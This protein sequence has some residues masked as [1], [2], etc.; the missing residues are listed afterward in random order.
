[1]IPNASI[2]STIN[3]DSESMESI[4]RATKDNE[5]KKKSDDMKE[6]HKLSPAAMIKLADKSMDVAKL[7]KKET[8][9]P[10]LVH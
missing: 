4:E 1:M 7:T 3:C 6:R 2:S 9:A 10:L 8:F 5:D